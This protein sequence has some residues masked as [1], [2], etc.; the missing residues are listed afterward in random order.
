MEPARVTVRLIPEDFETF[1]QFAI[2]KS[3]FLWRAMGLSIAIVIGT[4]LALP[5][6]RIEER[7]LQ[8]FYLAPIGLV[9]LAIF[10][11]YGRMGK[12]MKR[13]AERNPALQRPMLY[14][15]REEGLFFEN[16][17]E[18]GT[19]RWEAFSRLVRRDSAFYL[20]I[21]PQTAFVFPDR[22]F[23]TREDSAIFFNQLLLRLEAAHKPTL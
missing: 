12:K 1:V 10:F 19:R 21:S 13:A 3:I 23:A 6:Y 9:G 18:Q 2:G 22:C 7:S 11:S 14:E 16:E 15:I 5:S 4:L 20:M 17:D 8:V